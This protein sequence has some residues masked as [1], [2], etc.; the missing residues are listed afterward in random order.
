MNRRLAVI[1]FG[2]GIEVLGTENVVR[3]TAVASSIELGVSGN[4]L[5]SYLTD[6]YISIAPEKQISRMCQ[7]SVIMPW[8]VPTGI[9]ISCQF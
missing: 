5:A 3:T 1:E 7:P 9:S 4:I 8:N 6:K 2:D